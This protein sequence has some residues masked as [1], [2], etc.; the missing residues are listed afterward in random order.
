MPV[1]VYEWSSDADQILPVWNQQSTTVHVEVIKQVM[2]LTLASL[3][4]QDLLVFL[5][6]YVQ[7]LTA[8][9]IDNLWHDCHLG[10]LLMQQKAG[11]YHFYWHDFGGVSSKTHH[12]K[13]MALQEFV[14]KMQ[15]TIAEVADMISRLDPG[16]NITQPTFKVTDAETLK[17]QLMEF[18]HG[19]R[20]EVMRSSASQSV[21]KAVLQSLFRALSRRI[22]QELEDELKSDLAPALSQL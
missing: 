9:A 15:E 16:V 13:A 1:Q 5:I 6:G 8:F 18:S 14:R 11:Q 4:L 7:D 19:L 21:R 3:P 10:N 20:I 12:P 22:Y 17:R 2:P